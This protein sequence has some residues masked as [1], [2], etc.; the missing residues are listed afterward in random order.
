MR[1]L[2]LEAGHPKTKCPDR[3][4]WTKYFPFVF[5]HSR[6][7]GSSYGWRWL[8]R[9]WPNSTGPTLPCRRGVPSKVWPPWQGLL[10]TPSC[11]KWAPPTLGRSPLIQTLSGPRCSAPRRLGK[12]GDWWDFHYRYL[13]H[14]QI[15]KLQ[16][17]NRLNHS[18]NVKYECG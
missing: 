4:D 18:E 16:I 5:H 7:R 11:S 9:P 2:C 17:Q 13:L 1:L 8:R 6:P 12:R 14:W 10:V 3:L 15:M